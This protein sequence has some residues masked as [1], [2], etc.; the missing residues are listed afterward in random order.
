MKRDWKTREW[1][2]EEEKR[3]T[4]NKTRNLLS[5]KERKERKKEREEGERN[6][7]PSDECHEGK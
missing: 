6:G 2:R 3:W 7:I 4:A 1:K 5:I